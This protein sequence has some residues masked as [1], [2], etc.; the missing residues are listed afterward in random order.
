M[1]SIIIF[2]HRLFWM[3]LWA[4][5]VP[6]LSAFPFIVK[7]LSPSTH[8]RVPRIVWRKWF[9]FVAVTSFLIASTTDG[10]FMALAW[11]GA[12]ALSALIEVGRI[13]EVPP[14]DKLTPLL[15]SVTDDRDSIVLRTHWYLMLGCAL[16][17]IFFHRSVYFWSDNPH[18]LVYSAVRILPGLGCLGVGDALSAVVGTV[19]GGSAKAKWASLFGENSKVLLE[20]AVIK[21]K[22]RVGTLYGGFLLTFGIVALCI[23]AA[24]LVAD[25]ML[26][27]PFNLE[28]KL[29]IFN[30]V[31]QTVLFWIKCALVLGFGSVFETVSGG[32]DNLEVPLLSLAVTFLLF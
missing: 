29:L 30:D 18:W 6:V 22:S 11:C 27:L 12:L 13:Y 7:Y 23:Y 9:H 2:P 32:V 1:M 3:I 5:T 4:V 17:V 19:Y 28:S 26:G 24:R 8:H 15:E 21:K 20:N 16:P 14:F 31:K 10:S 25:K